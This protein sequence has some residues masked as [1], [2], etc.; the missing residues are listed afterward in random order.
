MQYWQGPHQVGR[1]FVDW[2]DDSHSLKTLHAVDPIVNTRVY[3]FIQP[4]MA[5]ACGG[6]ERRKEMSPL[7]HSM[8][9][10]CKVGL[11][12]VFTPTSHR[13]R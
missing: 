4:Q 1:F 13:F 6:E 10:L 7:N 11:G 12:Q 3:E 5:A 9:G 2:S 8:E